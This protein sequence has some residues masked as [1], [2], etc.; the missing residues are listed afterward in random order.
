M[1]EP[2]FRVGYYEGNQLIAV[3]QWFEKEA[4]AHEH[5]TR[6]IRAGIIGIV[7]IREE[8]VPQLNR[9]AYGRRD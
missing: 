8:L 2:G 7:V 9:I 3:S 5:W 1:P 4:S 6:L